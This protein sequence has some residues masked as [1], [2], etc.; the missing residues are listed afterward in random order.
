MRVCAEGL[1][2]ETSLRNCE[3]VRGVVR[4]IPVIGHLAVTN[5]TTYCA[6]QLGAQ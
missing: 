6:A 5:D 4:T 1:Q 3:S 2:I